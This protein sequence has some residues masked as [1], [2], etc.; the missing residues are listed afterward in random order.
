MRSRTNLV[1]LQNPNSNPKLEFKAS[2]SPI[3]REV[4]FCPLFSF[5][6]KSAIITKYYKTI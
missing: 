3:F 2:A 1:K 5:N 4:F 6:K